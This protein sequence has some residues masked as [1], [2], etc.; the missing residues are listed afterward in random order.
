M[1]PSLA[2]MTVNLDHARRQRL[3]SAISDAHAQVEMCEKAIAQNQLQ[4][5]SLRRE[6][7]AALAQLSDAK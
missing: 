1:L 7:I 6:L 2:N 4:L 3:A 5:L